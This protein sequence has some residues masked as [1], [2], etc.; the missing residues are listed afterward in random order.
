MRKMHIRNVSS[1]E[2]IFPVMQCT[3]CEYDSGST[4]LGEEFSYQIAFKAH[5]DIGGAHR[6]D[7]EVFS[8]IAD[9]ITVYNIRSVPVS[10]PRYYGTY[11]ECDGNYISDAPGVYPDVLEKHTN[12]VMASGRRYNS[13]WVSVKVDDETKSGTHEIKIV[14]KDGEE[15]FGESVFTL[16]VIDERIPKLDIPYTNWFH[17]DCISSYYDCE[18]FSDRHW[19]LIDKYMRVASDNGMNMIF[20]PVFT[21]PLDTEVGKE[22]TTVQLVDVAFDNGVYTFNFDKLKRWLELCRKNEFEY[23]EI[24]H[25]Y[26]QWGVKNAPKIVVW[27]NGR[28]IKKFGWD[29]DALGED[30]KEFIA[31]F[32]PALTNILEENW[33]KDKVYFHISDEPGVDHIERYGEVYKFFKPLIGDYRQIDALSRYAIYEKGYIKTPVVSTNRINDFIENNVEDKWAYYCCSQY[34]N[35]LSNRFIAMPSHRNRIMG[36]QLYKYN[37]KGFLHWGYNF[38]Y[39]MLSHHLVN[40]YI[41]NDADGGYPAGDAFSVYPTRDGATPSLRLKVFNCGMQDL[42]ACKLLESY[43]GKDK[44]IEIIERE[45]EVTFNS[46]PEG[47]AYIIKTREMINSK[48]KE[49]IASKGNK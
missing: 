44:V 38:Y 42:M 1:L 9:C 47:S 39:S 37:I 35:N 2:K 46:Y 5:T 21:P 17:C 43:I 29:T 25:L 40:P 30:Y 34:G 48:I 45:G 8:D 20:T 16:E 7:I 28:E 31:Q 32:I 19:E 26:T 13:I 36:M 23:I 24:S 6:F 22:R 27:E 49:C 33:D 14:F 12:F 3:A 18:T 4:L 15:Y 41:T 11:C 10:V